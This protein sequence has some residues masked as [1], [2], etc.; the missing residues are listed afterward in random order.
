ML[1]LLP[2]FLLI[3]SPPDTVQGSGLFRLIT[4][5][6][7]PCLLMALHITSGLALLMRVSAPQAWILNPGCLHPIVHW[8]LGGGCWAGSLPPATL[9]S[10]SNLCLPVLPEECMSTGMAGT[11]FPCLAAS[12]GLSSWEALA[13]EWREK[14]VKTRVFTS[15]SFSCGVIVTG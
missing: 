12:N 6:V 9:E 8:A 11:G 2:W 3:S 14:R 1:G 4:A 15:L 7:V 5:W 10:P 13:G